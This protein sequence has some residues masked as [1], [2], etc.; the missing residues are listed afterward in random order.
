MPV[1]I[2]P[3]AHGTSLLAR[4]ER[5]PEAPALGSGERK[6][7]MPDDD[8]DVMRSWHDI[9][10]YGHSATAMALQ[11]SPGNLRPERGDGR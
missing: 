5:A 7:R 9:L 6:R 8:A 1:A 4:R 2:A 3:E 11:R 10:V